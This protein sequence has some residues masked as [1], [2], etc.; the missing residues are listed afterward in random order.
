MVCPSIFFLM[1]L[2]W[3]ATILSF[4]H[5]DL[6]Y[7]ILFLNIADTISLHLGI[8]HFVPST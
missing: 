6:P 7:D 2:I 8:I 1:F 3:S 4:T 5:M